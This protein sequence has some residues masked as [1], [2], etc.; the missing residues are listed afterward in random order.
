[1]QFPVLGVTVDINGCNWAYD[2]VRVQSV[3]EPERL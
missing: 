1:M 2:F 3:T